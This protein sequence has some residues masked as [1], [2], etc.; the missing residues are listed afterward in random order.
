[1]KKTQNI[2]KLDNS[3][4]RTIK[5]IFAQMVAEPQVAPPPEQSSMPSIEEMIANQKLIGQYKNQLTEQQKIDL[6]VKHWKQLSERSLLTILTGELI[7]NAARQNSYE[8]WEMLGS[9]QTIHEKFLNIRN[10]IGDSF[11]YH[12]HDDESETINDKYNVSYEAALSYIKNGGSLANIKDE[13]KTKE[14]CLEAVKLRGHYFN[15]VPEKLI[16]E[17][18]C[19]AALRTDDFTLEIMPK[20]LKTREFYLK[21]ITVNPKAIYYVPK[22]SRTYEMCLIAMKALGD[23]SFVPVNL[24]TPELCQ[25]AVMKHGSNLNK[26]PP[27]LITYELCLEAVKRDGYTL[28]SVPY[29]MRLQFPELS[30]EA[31]KTDGYALQGVPKVFFEQNK[32]FAQQLCLE[33]VKQNGNALEVVPDEFS[34]ERLFI[35][36]LKQNGGALHFAPRRLKD[37]YKVC[38]MAVKQNPTA[39]EYVPHY[40]KTYEMCKIAVQKN[41]TCIS[42][43]PLNV[44]HYSELKKI[45]IKNIYESKFE[46]SFVSYLANI[47]AQYTY[48]QFEH[49]FSDFLKNFGYFVDN[50]NLYHEYQLSGFFT[51]FSSNGFDDISKLLSK[52]LRLLDFH[53]VDDNK[54]NSMSKQDIESLYRKHILPIE[55]S[56]VYKAMP[57]KFDEY[58]NVIE[59]I[60][61]GGFNRVDDDDDYNTQRIAGIF[62]KIP[63]KK[64]VKPKNPI[65]AHRIDII[66]EFIFEILKAGDEYGLILGNLTGCCQ[67]IGG[68]GQDCVIDGYTNPY[69]NFLAIKDKRNR[70]V[71]QTWLRLG[72]NKTL[73]FDNIEANAPYALGYEANF[74]ETKYEQLQSAIVAYA[75]MLKKT[76]NLNNVIVGANYTDIAFKE[77]KATDIIIEEELG[78]SNELYS[79]LSGND[80]IIARKMLLMPQSKKTNITKMSKKQLKLSK[81]AF[82]E[83]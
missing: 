11:G 56:K 32:E 83:N 77:R 41:G 38:L 27:K 72:K 18:I 74:D 43:V 7:L 8:I 55:L 15:Y 70:L 42:M 26:I 82:F 75:N 22:E 63:L 3:A 16:D 44:E 23:L 52:R 60:I 67:K 78:Y 2:L 14:L 71:A 39:L 19:L 76:F 17:D 65:L 47:S 81:Q 69:S 54:I 9:Q 58:I 49:D 36:A 79:D 30:M 29:E 51:K 4:I 59:T 6:I 37:N 24:M 66:D 25:I 46:K 10:F 1:M 12:C 21:A 31:V 35:I 61:E 80:Y 48:N 28:H 53:L 20:H 73:F 33:A 13:L 57:K 62:K 34:T 68:D 40:L 50:K 45:A 64:D 5:S